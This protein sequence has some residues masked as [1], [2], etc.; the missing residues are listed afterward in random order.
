MK[1]ALSYDAKSN[2][3]VPYALRRVPQE[4][5]SGLLPPSEPPQS[6]DIALAKVEKIGRNTNLELPSGRRCAL[7]VGDLMVGVFGNRYATMQFE[8]YAR[9]DGEHCD[10]L[11]I[12][13]PRATPRAQRPLCASI[14]LANR[15]TT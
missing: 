3:R 14:S 11:S 8:G 4:N 6:G 5:L 15:P 12:A 2:V 10:L 9:T 1:T 13:G 7:Y